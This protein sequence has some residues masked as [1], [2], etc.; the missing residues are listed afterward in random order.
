MHVCPRLPVYECVGAHLSSQVEVP[1]PDSAVKETCEGLC[2]SS[3]TNNLPTPPPPSTIF[4]RRQ[5]R[6][7]VHGMPDP[8]CTGGQWRGGLATCGHCTSWGAW[9]T[10]GM[11]RASCTLCK[12]SGHTMFGP[13]PVTSANQVGTECLARPL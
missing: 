10:A 13:P 4:A 3:R 12:P 2:A 1:L 11:W 5:G 8:G 9:R 7:A 6:G